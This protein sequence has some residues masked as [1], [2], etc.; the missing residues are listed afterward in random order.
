MNPKFH[1]KVLTLTSY[2]ATQPFRSEAEPGPSKKN[3]SGVS[4]VKQRDSAKAISSDQFFKKDRASEDEGRF[5]LNR[6]QGS[7]AISSDD[8]FDRPQQPPSGYSVITNA[9]L[10]YVKDGVKN[11]AERF[12]SYATSVMRRL[13]TDDY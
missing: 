7:A 10:D 13:N 1:T 8:F 4:K 3:E 2:S 6:F 5:R 11:V 12:S 9:N